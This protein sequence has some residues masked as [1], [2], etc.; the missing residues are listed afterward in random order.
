MQTVKVAIVGCG[1]VGKAIARYWQHDARYQITATT[2]TQERAS[3]LEQLA[4]Q[5][6]IVKGDDETALLSAIQAQDIVLLSIAPKSFTANSYESTY[7]ETAKNLVLALPQTSVKQV[8]YT[9]SYSVY[10]DKNGAWVD[11]K[12]PLAPANRNSQILAQTEE[13]LRLAASDKLK[14]CILR[15]GGIYGKGRELTKIFSRAFGMTRPGNGENYTNWIHL[16]DIVG[17]IAFVADRQ[18]DGIYNL[19]GDEPPL[20]RDLLQSLCDR[21]NL[22]QVTW[23]AALPET[24]SYNAR[25]SNQKLKTAGYKF[26]HPEVAI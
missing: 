8:I 24:R 10:G 25:V 18:L 11:E 7:L 23:D 12:S 20:S 1:Y 17:A 19:V 13:V 4:Q 15:L 14:V 6:V 22:P 9:G 16:D 26:I 5:V 3:E 21:Y 2:T